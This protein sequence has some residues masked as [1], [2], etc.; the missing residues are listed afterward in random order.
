MRQIYSYQY[1]SNDIY[2]SV[3]VFFI[4]IIT[5][6]GGVGGGGLLIPT[7]LL[8]GN[9]TLT[10]S[11]PLSII[12]IFGDTLVRLFYLF[13]KKHPLSNK[14]SIIDLSPLLLLI[15]FDGNSS[16]I[17]VIL[18]NLLP[19]IVRLFCI[20]SVLCLT[21]VKTTFKAIDMLKKEDIY[22]RKLENES[23]LEM[24]VIDGLANY[25][26]KDIINRHKNDE[27]LGDTLR[28]KYL[29]SSICFFIIS[30]LGLFSFLRS[31]YGLCN[32][33]YYFYIFGQIGFISISGIF[34]V[35]YLHKNYEYKKN[36]N[37]LFLQGDIVW[38]KI[39]F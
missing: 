13:P 14:R 7:F 29:N 22:L 3:L 32:I 4:S 37:Y 9:F 5:T 23:E 6:I 19:D 20:I 2:T 17:G 28:Q 12:T 18:A 8:I 26:D 15:P 36:S 25:I 16:F 35:Y 1:I 24:V 21:F 30:V 33:N 27:R 10:Q 39:I 11:I 31:S 38:K 34:I